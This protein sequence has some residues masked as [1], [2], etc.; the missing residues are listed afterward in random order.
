LTV[1]GA[2]ADGLEGIVTSIV[3]DTLSIALDIN[4]LTLNTVIAGTDNL[5][6]FDGTN[7]RK[8]TIDELIADTVDQT[9]ITDGVNTFVDTDEVAGKVTINTDDGT[10]GSGT[11]LLAT[12]SAATS[13]S[14][15]T[16][17][18]FLFTN[19]DSV[20]TLG[21]DEIQICAAGS[22]TD[23]DIAIKPKGAGEVILGDS[24]ANSTL[25]AGDNASGAGFN[26]TLEAGDS[27]GGDGDGGNVIITPGDANG[28]GTDG[29]VCITDDDSINVMC[30]EGVE[31][32]VSFLTTTNSATGGTAVADKAPRIEV[33]SS[34]SDVDISFL[35]K[36]TGTLSVSGTTTYEVNVTED[37]DIPNKKFVNT[38]LFSA[39]DDLGVLASTI[40]IPLN[41]DITRILVNVTSVY[42]GSTGFDIGTVASATRVTDD[43]VDGFVDWQTLGTYIIEHFESVSSGASAIAFTQ[44]TFTSGTGASTVRVEYAND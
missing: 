11:Q 38:V 39:V 34:D 8:I 33:T 9:R 20:D 21:N 27:T 13:S 19:E 26:L 40:T 30:F 24:A 12:F 32:A 37:D 22:A 2:T 14:T 15:V 10:G 35:P 36:G 18:N 6:I 4:G 3:G 28:A 7:N 23:I 29:N 31:T 1:A 16:D 43:S 44:S 17:A 5:V 41:A 42:A 25:S